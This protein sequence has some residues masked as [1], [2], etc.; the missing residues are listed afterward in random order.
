MTSPNVVC[1]I[2]TYNRKLLLQECIQN[3]LGQSYTVMKVIVVDNASTD[4][5]YLLTELLN[6]KIDYYRL[7]E[8]K[9]GAYGFNYGIKRSFHYYPDF[10]WLLDDDA[11]PDFNC[12]NL[13][14]N[15][16]YHHLNEVVVAPKV[17]DVDG[18]IQLIHRG[19]FYKFLLRQRAIKSNIYK[20]DY[21]R[22]GYSSFIGLL[23]P[24]NWI[25]QIGFPRSDFFIWF[26]DVEYSLR[27]SKLGP[28]ILLPIATVVHK[29]NRHHG[30]L[31]KESYWKMYYDVRNTILLAHE[32]RWKKYIFFYFLFTLCRRCLAVLIFDKSKFYRLSILWKGFFDGVKQIS[33]FRHE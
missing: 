14:V 17:I 11:I 16:S 25:Q 3:V 22:I 6:E 8:N 30:R 29:D 1:V 2:V 27:M 24:T 12:L 20:R 4:G 15:F 19:Y 32:F 33:G 10:V 21:V 18:N 28:I 7:E 9:G 26:D 5:T 23:L 13:L 31:S